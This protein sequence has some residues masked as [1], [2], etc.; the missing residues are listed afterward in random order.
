MQSE[1]VQYVA[2]L[3]ATSSEPISVMLVGSETST[4]LITPVLAEATYAL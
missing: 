4:T 2:R 1:T 3:A